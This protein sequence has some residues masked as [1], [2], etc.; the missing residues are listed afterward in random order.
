MSSHPFPSP[1]PNGSPKSV[2]IALIFAASGFAQTIPPVTGDPVLGFETAQSWVVRS[3]SPLTTVA[4]ATI[5]TQ[6]SHAFAVGNPANG[7]TLTS[8]AVASTAAALAGDGDL[9]A[10]FEVDVMPPSSSTASLKLLVSSP[11]LG[12]KAEPVA[13]ADLSGLQSGLYSTVKFP[14]PDT[15]RKALAGAAVKDLSFQIVFN[16]TTAT[17]AA[18][19]QYLFDNLRVYSVPLVPA[20]A[21]LLS[22]ANFGGSIDLA[23]SGETP[24]TQSFDIGSVQV[25]ENLRLVQGTV[26][27]T[28]VKLELG[29]DGV[30]TITCTY[31]PDTSDKAGETYVLTSCTGG[32]KAGALVGVNT[33]QLTIVGGTPLMKLQAQLAKN[34]TGDLVGSGIIPPMPTF[35]GKSDSCTPAPQAGTVYTV[36][37]SCAAQVAE[38][39]QIATGY[40][41]KVSASNAAQNWVVAPVA[42]R[43]LRHDTALAVGGILI[44][45]SQTNNIP[46]DKEGHANQGGDFDAYWHLK[47]DFNTT[48]TPNTN[49]SS[50]HFDADLSGHVVVFGGD[51]DVMEV[52]VVADSTTGSSPTA[53][54]SVN[55]FLFGQ[56]LPGGGSTNASTGF[57]YNIS[58]SQDYN[59]TTLNYWIFELKVDVSAS[60]SLITTGTLT[61]TGFNIAVNPEVSLSA[62]IFGGVD[63]GVASGG[64]DA[65]IQLLDVKAPITAQAALVV[66]AAPTACALDVN[67]SLN[68]SVTVS[69][70]GGKIDLVA[71]LGDCPFCVSESYTL[72]KWDPIL[73][74]TQNLVNTGAT[75]LAAVPLPTSICGQP[76]TVSITSPAATAQVGLNYSL[77]ASVVSNGAAPTCT[78]RQ[79]SV[80]PTETIT[81]TG[82][83][84]TINF[85]N[86][87]PH[88]LTL[89]VT[90]PSTDQFGR[91]ITETGSASSR[92]TVSALPKGAYIIAA[93]PITGG[94]QP[95]FNNQTVNFTSTKGSNIMQLTGEFVGESTPVNIT[96]TVSTSTSGTILTGSLGN[97][98]ATIPSTA[99]AN[100]QSMAHW[101]VPGTGTFII[102]MSAA[103]STGKSL[104]TATMTVHVA[105][106]IGL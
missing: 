33:A 25:P 51:V 21:G 105:S 52:K 39:N 32:V 23:A 6:G 60:A 41:N 102:R 47:G 101:T 46:F 74:T 53:T 94:S 24:V 2:A 5:R 66:N 10:V 30:P 48:A 44:N 22:P 90:D 31:G 99:L 76:L 72:V 58:R 79:W 104:G 7:T 29:H 64:V 88:T 18:S 85:Q 20:K 40:F 91:T 3:S 36:S 13:E 49:N 42:D 106:G 61:V 11:S 75:T 54:G 98:T 86:A 4:S 103:D 1:F 63:V 50:A 77:Q 9:G 26:G 81:V 78:G 56:Q 12:L 65:T 35:W 14:I 100:N 92:L 82:C 87:G 73:S 16:I 97:G 45:P 57:N 95:P 55:M 37:P 43:A 84:A 89:T 15:V 17:T 69:A 59:V 96:W 67:F 19:A 83:A 70:L 8:G 68:M 27:T 93:T 71:T 62:H 38:A 28:T 34:P 80:T